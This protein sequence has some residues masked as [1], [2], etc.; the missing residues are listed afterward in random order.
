[1]VDENSVP[2]RPTFTQQ[3]PTQWLSPGRQTR[4]SLKKLIGSSKQ[5]ALI[6]SVEKQEYAVVTS[7]GASF[8]YSAW[9]LVFRCSQQ[10]LHTNVA[11]QRFP[12]VIESLYGLEVLIRNLAA[13]ML[14]QLPHFWL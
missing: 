6:M 4:I 13:Q 10:Y 9:A 12:G 1:M 3:S 8:T 5:F 11:Q 2:S 7:K 14:G